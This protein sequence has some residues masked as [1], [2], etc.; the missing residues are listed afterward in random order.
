[1][2]N[3]ILER[4]TKDYLNTKKEILNYC[5][6]TCSPNKGDSFKEENIFCSK[7]CYIKFGKTL[8]L[9]EEAYS[10]IN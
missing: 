3:K 1:M 2:S 5:I 6:K 9:A 7:N 4:V 8:E 10:K